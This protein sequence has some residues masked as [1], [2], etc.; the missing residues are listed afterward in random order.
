VLERIGEPF[1]MVF[2]NGGSTDATGERLLGLQSEE[3]RLRVV[4]LDGNF[5]EASAL[6]AGASPD[7]RRAGGHARRRRP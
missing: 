7:A 3:P 6:T 4:D 1:E 5:G 2:V